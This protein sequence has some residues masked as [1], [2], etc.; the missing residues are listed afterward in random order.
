MSRRELFD[1]VRPFAPARK[2]SAQHV[3]LI[4]Q[5]ADLFGIPPE[6]AGLTVSP[7]AI[8]LL[9]ELEGLAKVRSDGLI[10][11]YPDPGPTGLPWTIGYGSTGPGITK[12]T[13]WTREQVEERFEADVAKFAAGVSEALQGAPTTQSQFDALVSF[14]YNVGLANLKGSTLLRKHRAGDHA[15]AAREFGKWVFAKGK[16]LN[17]LVRRRAAE[18]AL[19]AS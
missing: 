12:G 3:R 5:L 9:H 13:V 16:R 11:A 17:G 2:F 14:A 10:E 8:K 15:G 6:G 18:A 1:A 7:A 4:D 19:Y